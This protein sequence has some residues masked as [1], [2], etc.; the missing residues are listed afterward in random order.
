ALWQA[1]KRAGHRAGTVLANDNK[2]AANWSGYR[3]GKRELRAI[4]IDR[5]PDTHLIVIRSRDC[6]VNVHVE[7]RSRVERQRASYLQQSRHGDRASAK[8]CAGGNQRTDLAVCG[9][10]GVA[11]ENDA[12]GEVRVADER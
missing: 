11:A 5:S 9:E 2:R 10:R 6:P 1:R 12:A 4:E 7:P 8:R 3:D